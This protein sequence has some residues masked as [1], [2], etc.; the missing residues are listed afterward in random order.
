MN[1]IFEGNAAWRIVGH[2]IHSSQKEYYVNDLARALQMSPGT[3]S[4][5]CRRLLLSGSLLRTKSGNAVFYRLN[6][7][8]PA[9]KK[10]KA[11]WLLERLHAYRASY[12]HEDFISVA[13]YGSGASG[14]FTR[15]SDIDLLVITNVPDGDVRR[16][17]APLISGLKFEVSVLVR[18]VAQ[19]RELARKHDPFF[20]EVLSKHVILYGSGLVV[21]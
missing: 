3:A 19:W 17:L 13:L 11:A 21:G 20:L 7:A 1:L 10:L 15:Q 4:I 6:E 9:V 2:F 8:N 5:I 18:T 12:E 16:R 14:D